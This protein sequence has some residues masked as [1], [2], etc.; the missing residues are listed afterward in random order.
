MRCAIYA[1]VSTNEQTCENQLQELQM[2]ILG[3]IA[4]FERA[5]IAER[6]TCSRVRSF[7]PAS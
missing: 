1:R 6:I 4:E 7:T 3:A 2:H 5:R